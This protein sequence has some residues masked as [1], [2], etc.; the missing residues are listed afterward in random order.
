MSRLIDAIQIHQTNRR[1]AKPLGPVRYA[2][3]LTIDERVLELTPFLTEYNIEVR[4]GANCRWDTG[5]TTDPLMRQIARQIEQHVFGEFREDIDEIQ[6]ALWINELDKAS[7]L[8]EAMR[9][10]MFSA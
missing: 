6:R 9:K 7:D 5:R 8:L 4:L 3:L 2:E 1:F 10:K